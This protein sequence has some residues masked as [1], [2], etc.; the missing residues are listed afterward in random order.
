MSGNR[1]VHDCSGHALPLRPDECDLADGTF[2]DADGN[3]QLDVCDA[4]ALPAVSEWGLVVLALLTITGG[5][6]V[7]S[8]RRLLD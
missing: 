3:G 7:L 5:T 1:W 2:F 6:V 4:A 8:R